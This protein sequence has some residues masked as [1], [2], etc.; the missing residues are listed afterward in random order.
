MLK[1]ANVD[2]AVPFSITQDLDISADKI[3]L[4]L[5]NCSISAS[6]DVDSLDISL[7]IP[8]AVFDKILIEWVRCRKIFAQNAALRAQSKQTLT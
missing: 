6:L 5:H 2:T 7:G 8:T 4:H 1:K 3:F